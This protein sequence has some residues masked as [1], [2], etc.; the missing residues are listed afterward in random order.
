MEATGRLRRLRGNNSLSLLDRSVRR[1]RKTVL[2]GTRHHHER[3]LNTSGIL[4]RRLDVRNV[5]ALCKLGCNVRV[6]NTPLHK[7]RLVAHQQLVHVLACIAVNLTQPLLHVVERLHIG[8]IKHQD[9]T[10]CTAIV[11]ARDC[12]ETLL[13]CCVPNLQLDHF[14]VAVQR[15]DF[16]FPAVFSSHKTSSFKERGD[17]CEIEQTKSTPIVEMCE[18][19]HES[20]WIQA[21]KKKQPDVKGGR[22]TSKWY[23][24]GTNSKTK[25]KAALPDTRIANQKNL[26]EIVAGCV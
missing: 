17:E 13:S 5:H 12:A 9:D 16:L 15:F 21:Q 1:R 23:E 8:A 25:K 2:D 20:S 6:H 4:G 19:V 22:K 18:S 11:A 26:E 7:I 14:A 3:F 24:G 10:L